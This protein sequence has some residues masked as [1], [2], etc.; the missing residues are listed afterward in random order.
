MTKCCAKCR[1][2]VLS[3]VCL[4]LSLFVSDPDLPNSLPTLAVNAGSS[5]PVSITSIDSH[6]LITKTNSHTR[7]HTG[8]NKCI[9]RELHIH[10][11]CRKYT[12]QRGLV[13]QELI[14]SR[15]VECI[16]IRCINVYR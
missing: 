16:Q 12:R 8:Y 14:S 15:W 3:T 6:I 4:F 2:S 1:N 9:Y 5:I 7:P 10:V 11:S 13:L